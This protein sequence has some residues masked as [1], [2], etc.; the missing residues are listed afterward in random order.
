M[1][2]YLKI[3][4]G[5]PPKKAPKIPF[6]D[7]ALGDSV[8]IKMKE[9]KLGTIRQR[10]YRKNLEGKGKFSCYKIDDDWVRIFRIE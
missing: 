2:P 3:K 6:S 1:C 9:I 5:I 10:I 4:K 7:M 8:S